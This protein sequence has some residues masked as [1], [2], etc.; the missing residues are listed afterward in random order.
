MVNIISAP[1]AEYI[2]WSKYIFFFFFSTSSLN[3]I[4][5]KEIFICGSY[6][7]IAVENEV[8]D[9]KLINCSQSL[10]LNWIFTNYALLSKTDYRF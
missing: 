2:E 5:A 7:L 10:S 4:T 8:N 6:G 9:I 3:N 1:T